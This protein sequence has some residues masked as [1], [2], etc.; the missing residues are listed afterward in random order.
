MRTAYLRPLQPAPPA[1]SS[2]VAA[3]ESL[4]VARAREGETDAF[5]ELVRLRSPGLLAFLRRLLGDSEDAR[6]VAQLTFVRAWENLERYD[7]SWAFS[8]W[9]FRIASNLAVDAL[10]SRSSRSRTEA[11]N[12]RIV[13]GGLAAEPEGPAGLERQEIRRIFE[14]CATV[15]S[16][17]QRLVFVLH[18]LEE[19]E[20]REIAT[21]LDCREST[22]R[23][24]LFQAR[25]LLR[26][27][28]R[29]RYPEFVR[30]GG[31]ESGET[32]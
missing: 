20:S 11:E 18:E 24:H 12:F 4:L 15:L 1:G 10:R 7:A 8:T 23:N 32:R 6:D 22:V 28:I 30:R 5:A 9:L 13:R 29:R 17:K 19:K 14:E 27:E 31:G 26:G 16:E 25:R 3:P 21:L 2:E